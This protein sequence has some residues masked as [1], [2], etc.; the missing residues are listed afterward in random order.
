VAK[1]KRNEYGQCFFEEDEVLEHIYSNPDAELHKLYINNYEKF[2]QSIKSTGIDMTLLPEPPVVQ[3]S[4]ETFDQTYI[5][6]WNMPDSYKQMDLKSYLLDKCQNESEIQR[7]NDE[8]SQFE[9]KKFLDV[10]KFLVYFVDTLRKNNV[11]WG[12]GRGSSVS[13]FCLFLIGVH[14]INPIVYDLD[15]NEFMR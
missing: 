4:V 15:F 10:L 8:Y 3:H 12:L 1:T 13:S 5:N 6:D 11:V 9:S 2:N 14:K 7:V